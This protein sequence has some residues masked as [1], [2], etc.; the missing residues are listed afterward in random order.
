M[1]RLSP[2]F[3]ALTVLPSVSRAI[4]AVELCVMCEPSASVR[5]VSV[6]ACALYGWFFT[7]SKFPWNPK[8]IPFGQG[9][10]SAEQPAWNVVIFSD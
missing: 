6:F 1:V 4:I 9:A 10:L 2:T 8:T 5:L 3:C 7:V